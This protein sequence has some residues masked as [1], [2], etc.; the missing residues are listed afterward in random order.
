MKFFLPCIFNSNQF[1][2]HLFHTCFVPE[3]FTRHCNLSTLAFPL[4]IRCGDL[5]NEKKYLK[6]IVF[7][8]LNNSCIIRKQFRF[9]NLLRKIL[10]KNSYKIS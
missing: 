10:N 2:S 5:E 6:V 8:L 7:S 1:I 4:K 9:G 3:S